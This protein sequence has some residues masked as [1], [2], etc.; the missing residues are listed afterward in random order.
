MRTL[1][2]SPSVKLYAMHVGKGGSR[3]FYDLSK[4]VVSCNVS[5]MENGS[6][7]LTA[8]LQNRGGKYDGRFLPMDLV[9][10]SCDSHKGE[11]RLF[12]GYVNSVKGFSLYPGDY[13]L[14]ASDALYRLQRLY[15]DPSLYPSWYMVYEGAY[16][17]Y[18]EKGD[19][20]AADAIR[21]V[22]TDVAG[23]DGSMV[24]VG[25]I[26]QEMA[27]FAKDVWKQ[28]QDGYAKQE[29]LAKELLD[30]LRSSSA[31]VSG[32]SSGSSATG[33][34]GMTVPA[35]WK[36]HPEIVNYAL[37]CMGTPYVLGAME[38]GVGIDCSGLV[39]W[40]YG[41]A[42]IDLVSLGARTADEITNLP[43]KE[44]KQE[45]AKAGDLVSWFGDYKHNGSPYWF[46]IAI[47]D[48]HGKVVESTKSSSEGIDGVTYREVYSM[49]DRM[50][51]FHPTVL[52]SIQEV[53]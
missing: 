3:E 34:T 22:L 43:H 53:K 26:P 20:G 29:A 47:C 35:T 41:Q 44:V 6:G 33:V 52:D 8:K 10:A 11:T 15:W 31:S 45:D 21:S 4:D 30:V 5:L 13:T 1:S 36:G 37:S 49:Y 39:C 18:A 23:M 24:D 7:T 38:P 32:G 25:D 19:M 14:T 12:T 46:H 17:R 27:E 42:G 51:F 48:G 9:V 28:D 2:Y 50:V 40:A 16:D